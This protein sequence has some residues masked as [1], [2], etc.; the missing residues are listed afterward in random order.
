[1]IWDSIA[2]CFYFVQ[3]MK[4]P[5]RK[6]SF[7]FHRVFTQHTKIFLYFLQ[8]TTVGLIFQKQCKKTWYLNCFSTYFNIELLKEFVI[9]EHL[10]VFNQQIF[11]NSKPIFLI[12]FFSNFCPL[13]NTTLQLHQC[14]YGCSRFTGIE[15]ELTHTESNPKSSTVYQ[16]HK[17]HQG[18]KR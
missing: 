11:V 14:G 13:F 10:K 18:N 9:I 2:S 17:D 12:P 16:N 1:M 3:V 4:T 15:N 6:R 5:F 8:R 7:Q